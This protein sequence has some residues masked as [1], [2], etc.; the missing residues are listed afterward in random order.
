MKRLE[1]TTLQ[2]GANGESRA[3]VERE[4]ERERRV[5]RVFQK[6]LFKRAVTGQINPL[7]GS[8]KLLLGGRGQ[9]Y[10]A[11]SQVFMKQS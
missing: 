11:A 9:R 5:L 4:R 1:A 6:K 7:I 10:E 8:S 3:K 2:E